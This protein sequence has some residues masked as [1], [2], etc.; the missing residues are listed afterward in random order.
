[1]I[2][3]LSVNIDMN[4]IHNVATKTS[5]N[6]S[7]PCSREKQGSCGPYH[8]ELVEL[9]VTLPH[10]PLA[11]SHPNNDLVRCISEHEQQVQQYSIGGATAFSEHPGIQDGTGMICS[12]ERLFVARLGCHLQ[13]YTEQQLGLNLQFVPLLCGRNTNQAR[14]DVCS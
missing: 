7:T 12:M 1:M 9:R 5:T 14:P 2:R 13:V 4:T 6:R 10:A 3:V 8:A 11:A